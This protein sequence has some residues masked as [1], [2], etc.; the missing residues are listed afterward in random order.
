[1]MRSEEDLIP[2]TPG[3]LEGSPLLVLAPLPDDEVFGCG[4]VLV[5]AVNAGAEVRL[6]ILTDGAEQGDPATRRGEAIEAGF[7]ALILRCLE[8]GPED[9]PRDGAV[10]ARHIEALGLTGWTVED[11]RDWWH[12]LP[13]RRPGAAGG[14]QSPPTRLAVDVEGRR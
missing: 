4:G 6:V 10:L 12:E 1:M 3:R 13:R 11:A 2:Y 5:Q 7:E 9:R 14:S 8:K